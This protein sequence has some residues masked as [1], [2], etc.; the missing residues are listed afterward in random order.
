MARDDAGGGGGAWMWAE[1]CEM[2]ARAERLHRQ[3]FEPRRSAASRLPVWQPPADVLETE[4]EVLILVALPG[5]DPARGGGGDRGRRARASR[6]CA[7]CRPSSAPPPST[8]WNCRRG[9]SSAGCRC[10]PGATAPPSG[11]PS[12]RAACWSGSKRPAERG[13]GRTMHEHRFDRRCSARPISA[14]PRAERRRRAALPPDALAI[15]PV[16][17]A[18]LFP[19][20]VLPFAVNRQV[21]IAAVQHAMRDGQQIG[22]L[23]QRDP[24]V[25]EP[26]AGRPAPHR[27]G[28][29]HPAHGDHAGR[30][31]PARSAR[32]CSASACWTG[33]RE[34]PFIAAGAYRI[35]EP[36]TTARRRWRRASCN[37]KRPGGGGVGAAAA[38][39]GRAGRHGAG[40]GIAGA[41]WPTSSPPSST[42]GRTRS[43]RSWRPSTS[44][45]GS[46]G[47]RARSRARIEVLRLS[48]E[49]GQQTRASL[50]QRQREAILREQMASIQRQ[51]GE[52]EGKS[53]EIEELGEAIAK[54]GMPPE[55][56]AGGAQA[57]CAG[58]SGC[59]RP[60]PSTAWSA[61]TSTG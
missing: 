53:A 48:A 51:L 29:Q 2:L 20:A 52:D 30:H 6:A 23:M 17:E 58:W 18:V 8:G 19:G 14:P 11:A 47:F 21:S 12:P 13:G 1:A 50:D 27:H 46:T 44:S 5:V 9:A 4:R 42:C 57:S 36:D 54:A 60:R 32:A 59:R 39:A 25:A 45:R 28:G 56:E 3:F 43:R 37:L 33:W 10:R 7:R 49:I 55:V 34:R 40:A 31:A 26:G 35:E 16:R 22:V 41:L 24:Q 61:A 38:G 15:L